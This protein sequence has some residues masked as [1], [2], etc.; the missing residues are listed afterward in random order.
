MARDT[1]PRLSTV[2]VV[3]ALAASL[4]DRVLDGALPP[5]SSLA[6]TE[7]AAEYGV[8]RP[9]ARSAVTVLVHEGLLHREANKPATVP[10]LTRADVEDL[11]LLRTPLEI[12]ALTLLISRGSVPARE[13]ARAVADL[14]H[15][16][17]DAP[18]SAF[19]E[20][21]LRFHQTLVDAV[22]SPRLSRLY[23]TISGEVHLCMVQ[24]RHELG[25]DRIVS[26]HRAV[27]ES[28]ESGD[29]TQAA[30]CMRDHLQGACRSLQHVFGE[31]H[32]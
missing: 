30:R 8:S 6:E 26:E 7:I 13:A 10:R 22:G 2:S 15:L 29:T 23:R 28:L 25:R 17:A 4:R 3:D 31:D 18:H 11:F 1:A 5:G 27:L 21:D 20:A 32:G 19:V 16:A 14:D 24:T 12:E 9:T